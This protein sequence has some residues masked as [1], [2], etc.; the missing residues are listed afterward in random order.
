MA[1]R[2]YDVGHDRRHLRDARLLEERAL[3][4]SLQPAEVLTVR[5]GQLLD[6]RVRRGNEKSVVTR[7]TFHRCSP[8]VDGKT[9]YHEENVS[10]SD[11]ARP[12]AFGAGAILAEVVTLLESGGPDAVVLREVA[13]LARVSLRD[14]YSQFRLRDELIVE[15][16]GQWMD[17]N[18][19]R[20]LA[21]PGVDASLFDALIRQFRHIFE[22]WEQNPR[23]LESFVYARSAPSATGSCDKASRRRSR[24]PPSRA[25]SRRTRRTWP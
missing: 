9:R 7:P 25:W 15:A 12:T 1:A 10:A 17:T 21:E 20:P 8:S 14:V 18:V 5:L 19:Y 4:A 3:R 11:E 22:P 24:S 16:V 2:L 6:E 23:M 13:R